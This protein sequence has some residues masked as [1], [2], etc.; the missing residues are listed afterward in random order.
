MTHA[1]LADGAQTLVRHGVHGDVLTFDGGPST[2]LWSAAHGDL[3]HI[4]NNDGMLP[5]YLC[6]HA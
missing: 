2:Y 6:V 1:S 4:T 3:V 5:H